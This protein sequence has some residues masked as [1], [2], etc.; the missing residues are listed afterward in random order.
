MTA[1]SACTALF[2]LF[3]SVSFAQIEAP[4]GPYTSDDG[5]YTVTVKFGDG[6]LTVVE[7][8]KTSV[9]T[10]TGNNI[11]EFTNSVNGRHYKIEVQDKRTLAAFGST[12]KTNFY[13]TGNIAA[14]S[15]DHVKFYK[16]MADRY[17]A[18]MTSD[19]KDAQL[20]SFCS[21][22]ATQRARLNDE[23]FEAY[24]KETILSVR[25][26][27]EDQSKCPCPDAIPPT[28]WGKYK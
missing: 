16:E 3:V 23:G 5:R 21:G 15:P 22:A 25:L 1:R 24:A 7:P 4:S 11:Y 8:N 14:N 27:L 18:K 20:W 17:Q 6:N 26:I 28:L 9:Y 19:S 10:P 12:G 2:A 13:F